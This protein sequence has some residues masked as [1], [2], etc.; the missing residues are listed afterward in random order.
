MSGAQN[1]KLNTLAISKWVEDYE[2]MQH[3]LE[4]GLWFR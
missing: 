4:Y 1:I 2:V 3:P